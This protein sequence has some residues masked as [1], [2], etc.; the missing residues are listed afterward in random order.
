M[1]V[2]LTGATGFVGSHLAEALLAAGHSLTCLVRSPARAAPLRDAGCT[3][4]QGGLE[5]E[6][7]LRRLVEG[8]DTLHHVAGLIAAGFY[9]Q[10]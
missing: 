5:D 6:D 7:A 10:D 4:V 8:A 9:E 1:R 2:A 3:L